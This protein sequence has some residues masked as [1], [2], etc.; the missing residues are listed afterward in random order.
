MSKKVAT[1]GKGVDSDDENTRYQPFYW[2]FQQQ[3]PIT[4][5]RCNASCQI[6][7]LLTNEENRHFFGFTDTFRAL[8]A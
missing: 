3:I 8:T 1:L 2:L 6:D 7:V 5:R 4:T